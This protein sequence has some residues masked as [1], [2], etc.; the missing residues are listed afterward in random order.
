MRIEEVLGGRDMAELAARVGAARR[1]A[2][3]ETTTE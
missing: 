2:P 3:P 1:Q